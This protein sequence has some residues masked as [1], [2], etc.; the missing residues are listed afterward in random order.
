L[1]A[2]QLLDDGAAHLAIAANDEVV[3]NAF[4]VHFVDHG[5]P[6]LPALMADKSQQDSFR[7]PDLK[8]KNTDRYQE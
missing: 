6:D 3:P 2:I 1:R 5:F 4:E 7:K 8:G